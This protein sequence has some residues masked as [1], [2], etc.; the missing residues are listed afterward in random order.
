MCAGPAPPD[1]TSLTGVS[2]PV[3]GPP[4]PVVAPA[5]PEVVPVPLVSLPV[6]PALVVLGP[7]ELLEP[8]E[9]DI[10]IEEDPPRPDVS[11]GLSE[12]AIAAQKSRAPQACR[13]MAH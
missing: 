4:L 5:L 9:P 3:A 10:A 6:P 1:E 2:A 7:P 13:I 11:F 12:H 8:P